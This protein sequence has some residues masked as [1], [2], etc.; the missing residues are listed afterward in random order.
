MDKNGEPIPGANIFIED[1]YDGTSTNLDGVFAF[2]T[3][4]E[5]VVRL[6]VTF[7][8]YTPFERVLQLP[9]D[10]FVEVVLTEEFNHLN[11]VV[12]TA[13]SYTAGEENSVEV[14]K[15]LDIAT[16]AGATADI[17]GALNTLPGTQTVG[18]TGRLFVRGGDGY[19]TR[20]FIDGMEVL[21][22]YS[23]TA[24]NTPG[25]SRFSPFMFKGAS[26]STGGYSAEYGQALSSALILK[27]KDL[28]EQ[29]RLDL[30]IM[31]V[32]LDVSG[33]KSFE[34]GALAGKI[35]YT[36]LAP[37]M[38]LIDQDIEWIK[39]PESVEGN[40]MFRK[41]LDD[42]NILKIYSNFNRSNFELNQPSVLENGPQ[43]HISVIN[44]YNHFNVNHQHEVSDSWS[45]KSGFSYT[46]DQAK[47][48]VND[49][50][51]NTLEHGTHVKAV[52]TGSIDA[53]VLLT[54]G[55]ENF[56]RNHRLD[57]HDENDQGFKSSFN[58]NITALFAETDVY[59]SD[60][61][62]SRIGTRLEYNALQDR[63]YLVPRFSLA[64]QTGE[65][66]QVS[67]AYGRFNQ[68]GPSELLHRDHELQDERASHFII[69]YQRDIRNRTFRI[70][71]YY[72]DYDHLIR[73]DNINIPA[74]YSGDGTGFAKGIDLF[75]RDNETIK[76]LDYW[77]SYSFLDTERTYRD[78]PT[79][80]IPVFASQHN[81][82]AVFKYFIQGIK[83]QVGASYA[84][85]SSRPYNDPNTSV[86]NAGRTPAYHDLSVNLSWLVK[87]NVIVHGSVTNL[88]GL[89]QIF[90]YESSAVKDDNGR[91]ALRPITPPA[92]RFIF[93][94]VFITLSKDNIT[95]QLPLL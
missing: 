79:A 83:T 65:H 44:T 68:S 11:A 22:E 30:G 51:F 82:S 78:F 60:E 70:E 59:F 77:I 48:T 10:H 75:W 6:R 88:L 61:I 24:P 84:F 37:Y 3:E 66:S 69:N 20:T 32:G 62:V 90:G 43:Q 7:V 64:Y 28:Q 26:F 17:A 15:P 81:F 71:A 21:N 8:G 55:A 86:F 42:R 27:S 94:G 46:R 9:Q 54:F 38:G 93:L 18:E 1:T 53:K 56:N 13:G 91:Y 80:A 36:N 49:V 33:S 45:L 63:Y 4:T 95:N 19:E 34:D 12:I 74:T 41:Q 2:T 87:P 16:T 57:S 72:K 25:R 29:D 52:L 92:P 39:A 23:P 67:L 35:G 73:Y 58:Q 40:A 5:G 47:T 76:G 85:T 14:L 31:S 50:P 89:E